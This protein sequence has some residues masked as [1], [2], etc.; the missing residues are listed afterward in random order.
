MLES[1]DIEHVESIVTKRF[2]LRNCG[3]W[4]RIKNILLEPAAQSSE[5][6]VQQA[7]HKIT[8]K[9]C[10]CAY[11]SDCNYKPGSIECSMNHIPA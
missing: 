11:V 6:P 9:T 5:A 7:K 2:P 3:A 1:G 10:K 8:P 4:N